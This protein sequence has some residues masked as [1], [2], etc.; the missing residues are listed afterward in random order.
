MQTKRAVN[1]P[2]F[3]DGGCLVSGSVT[4]ADEAAVTSSIATE[5]RPELT[6]SLRALQASP[7][8]QRQGAGRARPLE[9]RTQRCTTVHD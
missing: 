6:R 8:F 1:D 3:V 7:E 9:H 2:A 4:P 5:E